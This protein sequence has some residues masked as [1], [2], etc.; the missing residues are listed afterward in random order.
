[1]SN[2]AGVDGLEKEPVYH[3]RMRITLTS[4]RQIEHWFKQFDLD[5][6]STDCSVRGY[7]KRESELNEGTRLSYIKPSEI[8]AVEQLE[9]IR[10]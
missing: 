5:I 4:G 3:F 9:T 7:K 10:E 2:P 1:M 6:D 8:V